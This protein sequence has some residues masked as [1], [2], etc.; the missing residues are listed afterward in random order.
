[1][2]EVDICIAD[3]DDRIWTIHIEKRTVALRLVCLGLELLTGGTT[4]AEQEHDSQ[5]ACKLPRHAPLLK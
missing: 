5:D 2:K 4:P 3:A 1:M